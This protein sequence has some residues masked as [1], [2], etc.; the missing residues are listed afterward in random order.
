MKF[1]RLIKMHIN[2]YY[3]LRINICLSDNFLIQRG[4]KQL[5]FIFCFREVSGGPSATEI[6]WD[7]SASGES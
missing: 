4:T 2:E 6:E 5:L 3:K 1:V 7:K